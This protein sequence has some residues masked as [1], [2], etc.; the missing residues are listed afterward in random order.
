MNSADDEGGVVQIEGY[1]D[2]IDEAIKANK[3]FMVKQDSNNMWNVV[4]SEF[5]KQSTYYRFICIVDQRMIKGEITID[6]NFAETMSC[7][8]FTPVNIQ[9]EITKGSSNIYIADFSYEAAKE[10]Q[11]QLS[12]EFIQAIY[13]NKVILVP[14]YP[15]DF[16]VVGYA[17]VET[18]EIDGTEVYFSLRNAEELIFVYGGITDNGGAEVYND[19]IL[20]FVSKENLKTINGLSLVGS[21]D[22]DLDSRYLQ[23]SDVFTDTNPNT[24]KAEALYAATTG[25]KYGLPGTRGE[26]DNLYDDILISKNTLKTINGESLYGSGDITISGGSSGSG[27]YEEVNHGTSDTTFTLT[28][29]TFH[30]WDE[31]T[32]LDLDFGEET[33]GVA[34]EYLFQFTSG[35]TTTTLSL[36]NSISWVNDNAPEIESG[37][38]YQISILKGIASFISCNPPVSIIE[39]SVDGN[40]FQAEEGMTWDDFVN[41]AYNPIAPNT[42]DTPLFGISRNNNIS[43]FSFGV[44]SL[45]IQNN[46][47]YVYPSDAV[48]PINYTL[49]Q[50]TMP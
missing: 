27:A 38:V 21:G 48:M 24:I 13:D 41:S 5:I 44:G 20:R 9:D 29:N 45:N 50:N 2:E 47:Q 14:L 25:D 46:G 34:N 4:F 37:K 11:F 33:S 16:G 19:G 49:E 7:V 12:S 36:P 35:S 43:Y 10:D 8:D 26:A 15:S 6:G 3:T 30:V 17:I 39:F 18:P 1:V 31:V 40:Y 22:I 28:P 32:S 23:S 42:S